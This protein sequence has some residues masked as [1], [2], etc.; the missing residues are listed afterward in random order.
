MS[1]GV[2]IT[3]ILDRKR[4]V[5]RGQ[6]FRELSGG[7]CIK[8]EIGFVLSVYLRWTRRRQISFLRRVG[9]SG[10]LILPATRT[11]GGRDV[12]RAPTRR[13]TSASGVDLSGR[14]TWRCGAVL[15]CRFLVWCQVKRVSPFDIVAVEVHKAM[16]AFVFYR[17][18]CS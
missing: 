13:S 18:R 11:K 9:W 8:A 15:F 2:S 17:V 14:Q 6:E 4:S 1:Y 7:F 10:H 5:E 12:A 3:E 16:F